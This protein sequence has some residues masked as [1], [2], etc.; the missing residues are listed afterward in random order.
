MIIELSI[1]EYRIT[2]TV[3]WRVWC[4]MR[5]KYSFLF[6][7]YMLCCEVMTVIESPD[8]LVIKL[9]NWR[10]QTVSLYFVY[11]STEL[12]K[13]EQKLS[14]NKMNYAFKAI[15]E[16]WTLSTLLQ[17]L[18]AWNELWYWEI[19]LYPLIIISFFISLDCFNQDCSSFLISIFA[20]Y[21]LL[22][23]LVVLIH[24]LLKQKELFLFIMLNRYHTVTD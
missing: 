16:V 7:Y 10:T 11:M 2:P 4:T 22:C 14:G 18:Y 15:W 5:N 6:H 9:N 13:W 12:K 24:L 23:L 3:S 1:S 8:L 21:R 20:G 17:F 19:L